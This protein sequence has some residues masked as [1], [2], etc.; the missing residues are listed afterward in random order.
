MK[1]ICGKSALE[2]ED[3][4]GSTVTVGTFDGIHSGHK[5]LLER[6]I[7]AAVEKNTNS[8][9]VTF[10]PH[11]QMV[12]GK[13]GRTEILNTTEEKLE[14]LERLNPDTIVILEFNQQLASL[15]AETFI[16]RI[17]IDCLNMKHFVV[18]YDH[19]FGKDRKGN[20]EL[21]QSLA[22]S[23]KYSCEVVRPVH[24]GDKPIKSSR[25]RRE[26]KT[27]DYNLAV[28]MLGYKYFLT[29]E[30]IKGTGVG[31]KLGF[32]TINFNI[33]PGKLLPKEG[34]YAARVNV[35]NKMIPGMAYIGGRLTFG[36][37]TITVEVNLFDFHDDIS[38][39]EVR[40]ILEQYTR[41]PK[42]F[43]A[44]D[45]L[46]VALGQDERQIKKILNM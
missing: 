22:D 17:L 15:E 40:L 33:P 46:I 21:V 16:K 39:K 43:S 14:L 27:G 34:V 42:K 37:E 20:Y 23:Y 45:E 36:D 4:P 32:P 8:V 44:P 12:L 29:G 5:V 2:K 26:L 38:G 19:S 3:I 35:D 9:V 11:P 6:L 7:K 10:D 28:K 13:R 24:N 41:P 25:I 30:I 18:G 1:V 31:K